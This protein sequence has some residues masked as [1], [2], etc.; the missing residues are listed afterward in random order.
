MC[1]SLR[2]TEEIG[3]YTLERGGVKNS[4]NYIA[5]YEYEF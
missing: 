1:L 3:R 5:K 2:F 4:F